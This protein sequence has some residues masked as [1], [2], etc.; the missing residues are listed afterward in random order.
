M[1]NPNDTVYDYACSESY[2]RF[3]D[4]RN[5]RESLPLPPKVELPALMEC[6]HCGKLIEIWPD[7]RRL[8]MNG[9]KHECQKPT[10]MAVKP[11]RKQRPKTIEI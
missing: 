1:H 2:R 9:E 3:E 11:I 6:M 4:L 8:D 7:G 10:I 5:G